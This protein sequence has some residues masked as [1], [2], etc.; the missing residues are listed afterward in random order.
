MRF[1]QS[2]TLDRLIYLANRQLQMLAP[3]YQLFRPPHSDLGIAL[4][5]Q[6]QASEIRPVSTLSGGET[7]LVSLAL[8]LGL[9][10]L[11]SQRKEI[12]TL[13]IDEGFGSLDPDTLDDVLAALDLIHS[14]RRLIGLIS[15]VPGIQ[16]RVGYLIQVVPCGGGRSRIELTAP[17]LPSIGSVV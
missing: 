10:G 14:G 1:A 2:L 4:I 9:A 3:R 13:F 12:E 8:A 7:F 11:S 6:D 5:D 17:G 15:H 16:E